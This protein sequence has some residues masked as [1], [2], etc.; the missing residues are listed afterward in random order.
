MPERCAIQTL[1][2]HWDGILP[3]NPYYF[4]EKLRIAV[5]TVSA[6]REFTACAQYLSRGQVILLREGETEVRTRFALAHALAHQLLGHVSSL[7]PEMT[8]TRVEYSMSANHKERDANRFALALLIPSEIFLHLLGT[9]EAKTLEGLA[10]TFKVS[11][12]A[13]EYR[14]T[15]LQVFA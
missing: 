2:S 7:R 9:G 10:K 13:I 5:Q 3:V 8:D 11:K 6:T 1:D 15:D 12:A 14:A 4:A